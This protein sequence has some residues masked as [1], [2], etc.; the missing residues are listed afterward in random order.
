M[1]YPLYKSTLCKRVLPL[2]FLL[3]VL[4]GCGGGGGGNPP[5]T[6]APPPVT[7]L[8]APTTAQLEAVRT[9]EFYRSVGLEVIGADYAYARGLTGQGITVG[10]LDLPLLVND[11]LP[12]SAPGDSAG[13]I[14]RSLYWHTWRKFSSDNIVVHEDIYGKFTPDDPSDEAQQPPSRNSHGMFSAGIIV[15]ARNGRNSHGTAYNSEILFAKVDNSPGTPEEIYPRF[16]RNLASLV[17]RVP[18]ISFA[19]GIPGDITAL[20]PELV[21]DPTILGN[22]ITIMRQQGTPLP[23]KT[24]FVLPTG[25]DGSQ[26]NPAVPASIA[27]V[28]TELQAVTI[29]VTG[30]DYGINGAFRAPL[31][32]EDQLGQINDMN[33]CGAARDYCLAAPA[34]AG[35]VRV[36]DG[37]DGI[38]VW[39][40]LS[41]NIP[42]ENGLQ[43]TR[44]TLGT[45]LAAPLVAGSLALLKEAFPGMGN[46]ELVER[47]LET[48]NSQAPYNNPDIYGHGMLD[49][50][51]ALEPVGNLVFYSGNNLRTGKGQ[52]VALDT[53]MV[54]TA[55]AIGDSL[56]HNSY[57]V[58]AFDELDTPFAIPLA[59]FSDN[60]ASHIARH[61]RQLRQYA[62]AAYRTDFSNAHHGDFWPLWKNDTT[63]LWFASNTSPVTLLHH[64]NGVLGIADGFAGALSGLVENAMAWS[65]SSDHNNYS[66][67]ITAYT[68][69]TSDTPGSTGISSW[70]RWQHDNI[71]ITPSLNWLREKDQLLYGHSYGA[72]ADID[73]NSY[74]IDL[75]SELKAGKYTVKLYTHYGHSNTSGGLFLRKAR[76]KHTS[77]AIGVE[78]NSLWHHGDGLALSW[79][80]PLHAASGNI[81]MRLPTGRDIYGN[82]NYQNI[83]LDAA[84][85]GREQEVSITY[86]H[87]LWGDNSLL[88][89]KVSRVF[90]AGHRRHAKPES[91]V[92]L[93]Y[94]HS[95]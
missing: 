22:L 51:A 58:T 68:D 76:L 7:S 81:N 11:Y 28:I 55:T 87:P 56:Q 72:F 5:P 33:P 91:N 64:D 37:D 14:Y 60:T 17:G 77:F 46:H 79:Q 84:P 70:F 83:N 34:S 41:R 21:E 3:S 18:V 94:S 63:T 8:P 90:E 6:A 24:V 35:V 82:L 23:M 42:L 61:E 66:H 29:A 48:A 73:S 1:I 93:L 80:Q 49:L 65:I 36:A 71:T 2:L 31:L 53:S 50:K 78:R 10:L 27:S 67:G 39:H 47:L 26:S 19:Y 92:L 9:P 59:A 20:S 52:A 86:V 38:R 12:P 43:I 75:N 13:I 44:P 30:L 74:S 89:F 45:S 54:Q 32:P 15:A 57:T 62:T 16:G 95:F 85:S 25:N 4:P 88:R 40:L 69:Y